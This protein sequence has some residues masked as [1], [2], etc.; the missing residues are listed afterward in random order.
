VENV[1]HPACGRYVIVYV[2]A[3]VVTQSAST[4]TLLLFTIDNTIPNDYFLI[5][6]NVTKDTKTRL[7][8]MGAIWTL[9]IIDMLL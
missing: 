4:A 8:G 6:N 2:I 3:N 5:C 7:Y 1:L 9:I